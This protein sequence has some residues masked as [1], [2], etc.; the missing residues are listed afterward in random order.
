MKNRAFKVLDAGLGAAVWTFIG[1]GVIAGYLQWAKYEPAYEVITPEEHRVEL[2]SP[3]YMNVR[4]TFRVNRPREF[5]IVRE[6]TQGGKMDMTRI[7]LPTT[8]VEYPTGEYRTDRV[9]EI[10]PLKPGTYVLANRV[11][12][13]PNIL[14]S[15][16]TELPRLEL[17]VP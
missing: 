9:Q 16:C 11:C 12:W 2:I 1:L 5:L 13:K 4:R 8:I 7:E 14:K 10:P 17:V 6:L 3:R 15:E